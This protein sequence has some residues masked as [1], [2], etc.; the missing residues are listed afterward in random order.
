VSAPSSGGGAAG[1]PAED[2]AAVQ[3]EI[4]RLRRAV[5]GGRG[6]GVPAAEHLAA[7]RD[8]LR[9]GGRP[10][11]VVREETAL[12]AAAARGDSGVLAAQ[13]A[14]AR[15]RLAAD[16]DALLPRVRARTAAARSSLPRLAGRGA[17]MGAL[18]VAVV[19]TVRLVA[20]RRA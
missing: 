11:P 7:T 5:S 16:L 19:L 3:A 6:P 4:A 17:C 14:V 20:S 15:A 12:A 18:L 1:R 2:P 10:V 13:V 9:V 8:R